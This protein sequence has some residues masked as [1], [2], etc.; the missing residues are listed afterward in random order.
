MHLINF[1][2]YFIQK[3]CIPPK[4]FDIYTFRLYMLLNETNVPFSFQECNLDITHY[5]YIFDGIGI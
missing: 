5:S 4:S 3:D 1:Y 2:F